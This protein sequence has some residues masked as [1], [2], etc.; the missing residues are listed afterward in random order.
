LWD[1]Q[2]YL[3]IGQLTSLEFDQV[4]SIVFTPDGNRLLAGGGKQLDTLDN[5]GLVVQWEFGPASWGSTSCSIAQRNFSLSEWRSYFGADPYR[6][7]CETLPLHPSVV[8]E[9]LQ[10]E[11][12]ELVAGGLQAAL[13]NFVKMLP[14]DPALT[15]EL[16]ASLMTFPL[17]DLV[18]VAIQNVDTGEVDPAV[19]MYQAFRSLGVAEHASAQ[20]WNGVCWFG[21]LWGQAQKVLE[22]CELAV[23]LDPSNGAFRDSRGL[24]LALT[25]KTDKAIED[26]QAFVDWCKQN[27]CYDTSGRQRE[28]WI[29][30]L[31][32]GQNPFDEQLL[33]SL[34]NP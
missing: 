5:R 17:D 20:T 3:S 23:S 29:T 31:K 12:P 18:R 28:E 7:T 25:G 30:A 26:F 4:F 14:L 34:R 6:K 15:S 24:A 13:D 8:E 16:E 27:G 2:S 21:S 11:Q 32:R 1:T 33:Q 10:S 9:F 22:I 19:E